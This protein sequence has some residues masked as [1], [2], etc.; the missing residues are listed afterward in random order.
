MAI[1]S[2]IFSNKPKE[3][4]DNCLL[5][6]RHHTGPVYSCQFSFEDSTKHMIVSGGGDGKIKVSDYSRRLAMH[7]DVYG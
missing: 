7:D 3:S 5:T 2:P 1:F 6:V 4:M